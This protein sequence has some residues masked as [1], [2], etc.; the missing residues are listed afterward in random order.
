MRTTT[1]CTGPPAWPARPWG[2]RACSSNNRSNQNSGNSTTSSNSNNNSLGFRAWRFLRGQGFRVAG[3][4]CC[5]L[6]LLLR[7]LDFGCRVN[8]GS[9]TRIGLQAALGVGFKFLGFGFG[10]LSF[11]GFLGS[12][13]GFGPLGR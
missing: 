9:G 5:A 6:G 13:F 12:G 3:V 11:C 1:R 7:L 2:F 10:G 8:T 4:G